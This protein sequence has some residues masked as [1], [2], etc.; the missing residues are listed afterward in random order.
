MTDSERSLHDARQMHRQRWFAASGA[1]LGWLGLG[2]Q[3]AIILQIRRM[4]GLD[5]A[6]G[7][8][9]FLGYFTIW[10]NLLVACALTCAA[11]A[12]R[13]R[14]VEVFERP[15]VTTGIAACIALVAFTYHFLLRRL[16]Q[17]TGSQLL[18]DNLLHYVIPAL[19]L[20]YWWLFVAPARVGWRDVLRWALFPLIYLVFALLRGALG[21]PYAYP[22]I[23]AGR[24]GYVQVAL[25]AAG[26]LLGFVGVAA[27]LI[28]LDGRKR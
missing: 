13:L 16:W 20:M 18:A 3:L 15:R 21:G 27:I 1:L 4:D 10:S 11:L 14:Y 26:V 19:F 12:L 23:D 24:L 17:P 28:W 7:V 8:V 9:N 22:F 6:G 5:L 25:N 2:L